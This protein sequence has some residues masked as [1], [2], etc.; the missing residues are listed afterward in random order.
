MV[1]GMF[2]GVGTTTEAILSYCIEPGR[3]EG[4]LGKERQGR[5]VNA[6]PDKFRHADRPLPPDSCHR[7]QRVAVNI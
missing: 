1:I 4:G 7:P 2:G 5:N 6:I 3:A